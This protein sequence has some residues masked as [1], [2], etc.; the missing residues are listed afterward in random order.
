ML[1][2]EKDKAFTSLREGKYILRENL[3]LLIV[4]GAYQVFS[5][6]KICSE[7]IPFTNNLIE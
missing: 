3:A 7:N 5:I 2:G 1:L 4:T 6:I